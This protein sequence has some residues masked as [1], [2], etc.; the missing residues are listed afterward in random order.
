VDATKPLCSAHRYDVAPTVL[1]TLGVPPNERTDGETLPP[2]DAV[3]RAEYAPF[4]VSPT[5][6]TGGTPGRPNSPDDPDH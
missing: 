2:V 5:D 4:A 6:P 3:T 1:S